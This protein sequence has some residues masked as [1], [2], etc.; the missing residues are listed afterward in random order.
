MDKPKGLSYFISMNYEKIF[1]DYV[2][3]FDDLKNSKID[4]K[5]KHSMEVTK[6]MDY[7]VSQM[8]VS[9]HFKELAHITAIFHDIG[10]FEQVKRYNTFYDGISVD[11]AL[12]GLEVLKKEKLLDLE[13]HDL[14]MVYT[15]IKNHNRY[16]IEDGLDQDTELLCKLIRDADKCDIFRVFATE[17]MVD[18]MGETI[19][20]VSKETITPIIYE[21]ILKHISIDKDKRKTGLDKWIGFL[22]F[23]YD[24]NFKQSI[25]Y[26]R[27]N[28]YYRMPFDS[29]VFEDEKTRN[30]ISILLNDLEKYLDE[31]ERE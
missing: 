28:R 29:I 2:H 20:Q 18:T 26:L 17:D 19:E 14:Y 22:G 10:R 6:V 12:L 9:D 25:E 3:R 23:I 5:V 16:K 21:D 8:K 7:L 13:D 11:H 15:A 30:E 24:L 27:I 4:L 1:M 31:K